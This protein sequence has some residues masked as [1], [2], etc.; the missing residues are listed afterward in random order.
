MNEKEKKI[1]EQRLILATKNDFMGASG[2]IGII[3]RYLGQDILSQ[4]TYS[5]SGYADFDDTNLPYMGDLEL[6]EEPTGGAFKEERNYQINPADIHSI[7]YYY[8]GL[9]NG[10]HLELRYLFETK[11]LTV[12][13]RGYL[14][15]KEMAGELYAYNPMKD[16]E[17][18]IHK[19]HRSAKEVENKD[20]A[21]EKVEN[22][23][24]TARAKQSWLDK[25]KE[26]WGI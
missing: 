11:E 24:A 14:V 21:E 22:K 26:R 16:W 18:I 19:L 1:Q 20:K 15:F 4:E 25:M 8:D 5:S 17:I 6:G 9:K 3:L 7:G 10:W 23:I 2:K 13:Y 12:H